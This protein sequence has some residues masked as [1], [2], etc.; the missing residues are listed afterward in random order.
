MAQP[1]EFAPVKLICGVI[2][3]ES[4]LYEEVKARLEAEWG[5]AD[6]E[7]PAFPFDLTGYYEDEMGGDLLRRFLSFETLVPPESLPAAKLWAIELEAMVRQGRGVTGRPVNID[8]GY[9]TASAVVMAT[10]KDF[11]HRIPLARG[12]YAHLECLFTR[13]GVRTLDWTYPDLRRE[14]PQ[15]YFREVREIYLRQLRERPA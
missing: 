3:R 7:S 2:Y 1:R 5:R 12:I 10:A 14:P 13:T 11:A 6:S 9:L 8:P 15:A 4:P